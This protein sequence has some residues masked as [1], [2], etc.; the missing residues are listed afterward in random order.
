MGKNADTRVLFDVI[1][2]TSGV[3]ADGIRKRV[4][5]THSQRR[6]MYDTLVGSMATLVLLQTQPTAGAPIPERPR[7]E[8]S[9][10]DPFRTA[11]PT[12]GLNAWS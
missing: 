8:R 11:V 2:T 6:E 7:Y 3:G 12:W 10:L 1:I 5:S 9:R 4:R